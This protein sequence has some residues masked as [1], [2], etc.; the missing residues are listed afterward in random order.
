M[1]AH[2]VET[3]TVTPTTTSLRRVVVVEESLD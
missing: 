3:I 1:A 2:G